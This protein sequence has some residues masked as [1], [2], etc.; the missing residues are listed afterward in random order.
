[1]EI[2]GRYRLD[3]LTG[4]RGAVEVWE[5][6]DT[7]L[8]RPVTVELTDTGT[9]PAAAA[10]LHHPA[11]VAV[12]DSGTDGGRS[13]VVTE[14]TPGP[15]LAELARPAGM[16]LADALAA[17]VEVAD[18]LAH[19]HACGVAHGG[20][21]A[22]RVVWVDGRARVRGFGRAP[23]TPADVTGDITALGALAFEVVSGRTPAEAAGLGLR[24]LRAGVPRPLEDAVGRALAG[25]YTSVADLRAD[26][27]A[28]DVTDDAVPLVVAD[29][30][31]PQGTPPSFRQTE[32]SWL[33]PA[34]VIVVVTAALALAGTLLAG[35]DVG[36]RI[37]PG[38]AAPSPVV[39][40]PVTSVSTFDPPPGDGQERDAE[41]PLAV[42]GNPASAWRTQRY[43]RPDLGGLKPG[44]GLV[45]HL[46]RPRSL[47]RLVV[48][49]PT[50]GWAATVYVGNPAPT[51]A[52]WGP[53]AAGRSGID[54]GATFDLGGRVG[55][56]VLLWIT[57]LGPVPGGYAAAVADVRVLARG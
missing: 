29:D 23:A 4:R 16:P 40:A 55:R 17:L 28:V 15:T 5:G 32:R 46:D 14:P 25:G 3:R 34:T 44:V 24:Q 8:S 10:R 26:L 47:E 6:T 27:A 52:G 12:F 43:T 21:D 30:T 42:D 11:V 36:R 49:S 50:T 7:V 54:G 33:V 31:P 19:A 57:R 13:F 38:R 1:V 45:L 18:A 35:T 56:A 22:H 53:P 41:A 2:A 51:L 9:L 37:L 39:A 48:R 20:L